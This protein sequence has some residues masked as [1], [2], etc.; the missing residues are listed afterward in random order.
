MRNFACFREPIIRPH[1]IVCC[2]SGSANDLLL[3]LRSSSATL[4]RRIGSLDS[5]RLPRS[6]DS[7]PGAPGWDAPRFAAI[8]VPNV[9]NGA[10]DFFAAWSGRHPTGT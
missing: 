8:S 6:T 1:P 10:W 4:Y 7:L 5:S 2:K 3:V 9:Y